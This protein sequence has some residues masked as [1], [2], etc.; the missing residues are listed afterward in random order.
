M[1]VFRRWLTRNALRRGLI[2]G[3]QAWI[4]VGVVVLGTRFLRRITARRP[5]LILR[6][7]I[8]PGE[9]FILS[10]PSEGTSPN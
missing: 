1:A 7:V 5:K 4:T 6:E 3:N 8:R 9:T 2:D 10:E